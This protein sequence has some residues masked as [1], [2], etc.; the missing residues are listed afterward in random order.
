[1][2]LFH[3]LRADGYLSFAVYPVLMQ[4][5]ECAFC[6]ITVITPAFGALSGIEFSTF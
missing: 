4:T 6:G 5:L 1:M 3:W 2:G